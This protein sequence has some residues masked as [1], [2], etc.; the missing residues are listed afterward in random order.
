MIEL[1]NVMT[2]IRPN[3]NL[4]LQRHIRPVGRAILGLY[5]GE[6]Q[7][8]DRVKIPMAGSNVFTASNSAR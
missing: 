4:A 1:S 6:T 3:R 5:F 2:I 8:S 7:S